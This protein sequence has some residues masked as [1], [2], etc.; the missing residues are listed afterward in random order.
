MIEKQDSPTGNGEKDKSGKRRLEVVAS[1]KVPDAA[2]LH[3][4]A[5]TPFP[6]RETQQDNNSTITNNNQMKKQLLILLALLAFGPMAWA[7]QPTFQLVNSGSKPSEVTVTI[8]GSDW[9]SASL[10]SNTYYNYSYT[11]QIYSVDEIGGRGQIKSIAFK[12]NNNCTRNLVIYMAKTNQYSFPSASGY[13][14][15]TKEE[16]FNGN[17]TFT[18]NEWTTIPLAG[19]GFDFTS[20]SY[21]YLVVIVDDNSGYGSGSTIWQSFY[22]EQTRQALYC[23]HET[24]IDPS[25]PDASNIT[26]VNDKSQIQ[27]AIVPQWPQCAVSQ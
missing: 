13:F 5:N 17:V 9:Q 14:S 7:Q 21:Q 18:A 6:E 8:D 25:S 10:P 3:K 16:V 22:P 1:Q 27:L 2:V 15:G 19:D 12:G 23:H 20:S 26:V 24:D 4:N 11:Q